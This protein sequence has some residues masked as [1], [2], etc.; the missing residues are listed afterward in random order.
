MRIKSFIRVCALLPAVLLPSSLAAQDPAY[1]LELRESSGVV[2]RT[3]PVQVTLESS[4]EDVSGFQ[5]GVCD[6]TLIDPDF[7]GIEVGTALDGV[8]LE[9]FSL[10]V[11]A[12]AWSVSALLSAGSA[13]VA[14]DEH[15][16]FVATYELLE[17]GESTVEFCGTV[18]PPLV[19]TVLGADIEP[20]TVSATV[21][22]LAPTYFLRGDANGDGR[23]E[24]LIDGLVL[25]D[26]LATFFPC[27]AAA[28]VT[29]D[30]SYDWVIDTS[31]L[32]GWW[33]GRDEPPPAPG[34][35]T[36]G[37]DPREYYGSDCDFPPD[38]CPGEP[39]VI[40]SDSSVSLSLGASAAVAAAGE[41]ATLTV[42]MRVD[43][44]PVQAFQLSVCHE[45]G[46]LL[47][48][49]ASSDSAVV[50]GPDMPSYFRGMSIYEAGWISACVPSFSFEEGEY[51]L[52]SA[53]YTIVEE[54]RTGVEFCDAISDPALPP[55][56]AKDLELFRPATTAGAIVPDAGADLSVRIPDRVAQLDETIEVPVLL[57][58]LDLPI[59]G[60][61][62]GVCHDDHLSLGPDSI[63]NGP[64]LRDLAFA[65]HIITVEA[66]G[67]TV[68]ALLDPGSADAL[69][70]GSD[71]ILYEASYGAEQAGFSTLSFCETLGDP[72]VTP[73]WIVD[74]RTIV[75]VADDS[76]ITVRAPQR[77]AYGVE[78]PAIDYDPADVSAGITFSVD[79]T[80]QE[81][82]TSLGFPNATAGFSMGIA[83]DGGL[84]D[85]TDARLTGALE[86][87]DAAAGLYFVGISVEPSGGSD[88]GVTAG[89]VYDAFGV[90]TLSFDATEPVLEVDYALTAGGLS[91]L[92]GNYA[93]LETELEW[94]NALGTPEV[95]NVVL[96]STPAETPPA[97]ENGV[98]ALTARAGG[99]SFLR[100]D[101]DG[102]GTVIALL[103]ALYLLEWGFASSAAPPCLD[104]ADADDS[105][106]VSA[107]LDALYLLQWA[108][109]GGPEPPSPGPYFC[110]S[111]VSGDAIICD[112]SLPG[113][114]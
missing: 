30:G 80:I 56:I 52:F 88:D 112:R 31:R 57:T 48:D 101:G 86:T 33:T 77:F 40:D 70:A 4:A 76:V 54:G 55:R 34:P 49:G 90:A 85:A 83:H 110:G 92:E 61:Q 65:S 66:G 26:S 68:A 58:T 53:T 32:V 27:Q 25:V 5:F 89:V 94:S 35:E 74:G 59:D 38:P 103:D 99:G 42:R 47:G 107:L 78:V 12:D 62:W 41:E 81:L 10:D 98:V 2:E 75:P 19:T 111:D 15:Q 64:V 11:T 108:F 97:L 16:L 84:L 45:E 100:G 43:G 73:E 44:D 20:V 102:D 13:L 72:D 1:S 18:L 91:R 7:G 8:R 113:C 14:G 104:A 105:G 60:W 79:L 63:V 93:G 109:L 3:A 114:P 39:P 51:E 87:L 82:E 37:E 6:D 106:S 23:V 22:V 50:Y 24:G 95:P 21:S 67:W 28:D 9:T 29:G 36:C 96:L 69:G 17:V 46:L 71:M